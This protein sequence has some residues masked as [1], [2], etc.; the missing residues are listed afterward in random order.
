MGKTTPRQLILAA[1]ATAL[2]LSAAS[3]GCRAQSTVTVYGTIDS[4]LGST[5]L[6][7]RDR[8]SVVNEGGM[9][10]SNIGFRGAED[11]GGNLKAVFDL[12]GFFSSDTG[13]SGRFPGDTGGGVLFGRAA[14]VGLS[15][16]FGKLEAGSGST[17]Y[18]ISLIAFNPFGDSSA[19]S[20][21]FLHTFTGGQFPI[22][23]PPMSGGSAAGGADTRMNNMIQYQSPD[24]GGLRAS[25]QYGMGE[26]AGD[27]SK[28]RISSALFYANG[29]F[30]A[31]LSYERD[32]TSLLV[33]QAPG[34]APNETRQSSWMGGLS[35]DLGLAKLFAQYEQTRQVFDVANGDRVF[36][37]WQLGSSVPLGQGKVLLSWA[38]SNISLPAGVSPYTIVTGFA[39]PPASAATTGVN[40]VRNTV[41]LGYD[42]QI[43]RRTD[44][45]G[46][47][48]RDQYTGLDNGNSLALGI[49]HRF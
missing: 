11:L 40:P 25:L 46:I 26:V 9:S 48:M 13:A 4:Y 49:R 39:R 5:Q 45:Y 27:S 3:P 36:K 7:G 15:G 12:N 17:P 43:S 35:Y 33:N 14:R 44:L 18:F 23:S 19:F 37:T 41:S 29:P 20:P 28:N 24:M 2:L 16:D 31:T 10:S 32:T 21:I 38:H 6:A 34:V 22:S 30:G 1:T 47:V 8:T 42:Y